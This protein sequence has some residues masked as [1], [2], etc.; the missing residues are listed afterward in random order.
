MIDSLERLLKTNPPVGDDLLGTYR[1]LSWAY[2]E[3]DVAKVRYYALKGIPLAEQAGYPMAAADLYRMIGLSYYDGDKFDSAMYYYEK[4]LVAAEQMKTNKRYQEY[5]PDGTYA[6]LYGTIGNLYNIQGEYTKAIEYYGKALKLLEKWDWKENQVN[7]Y[8]NIGEM[9]LGMGNYEQ[10]GINFAK[11]D[12]I[13]L[14]TGDSLIMAE[15]KK[16]LIQIHLHN[17]DYDKAESIAESAYQ[18][19]FTHPEEGANKSLISNLLSEIYLNG[20]NDD[21]KAETYAIQGLQIA[22]SLGFIIEK[23]KS[24][25]ILS[26]IFLKRSDWEKTKQYALQSLDA[27][28]TEV[29]NTMLNY[30]YLSKAYVHLGNAAKSDEYFDKHNELQASWSNKHYQSAIREMEVKYETEKKETQITALESEKKR[31]IWLGIAGGAVLLLTLAAFFFLWRWTVQKKRLA[32]S[33]IKQLE[34]EK[35]LIA[36]QSVL[37]GEVQ[38]RIRLA[39]DLHDGLGSILAAAKYNLID[40]RKSFVIASAEAERFDKSIGLLDDSMHEMRRI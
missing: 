2:Q 38:E 6:T 1:N 35:Q 17:K 10:A 4:A 14:L 39:R 11:A 16:H 27:D 13:S 30:E 20:F 5:Q 25:S 26:S 18:Y 33:Q 37:D 7:A 34:Q 23:S 12:S 28:S 31:M 8:S 36:T 19:Y 3:I 29:A 15:V 32:E 24:L 21:R 40:T 9:Y 22:D